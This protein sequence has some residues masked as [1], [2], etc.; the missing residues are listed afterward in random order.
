MMG[1]PNV[2]LGPSI[3]IQ[4]QRIPMLICREVNCLRCHRGG[5][6]TLLLLARL[7]LTASLLIG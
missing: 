2:G 5:L 7:F 6:Y 1:G 3:K 4:I